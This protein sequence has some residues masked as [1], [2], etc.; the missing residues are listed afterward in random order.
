MIRNISESGGPVRTRTGNQTV[1]SGPVA[2]SQDAD[3]AR[4]IGTTAPAATDTATKTRFYTAPLTDLHMNEYT[5]ERHGD[6]WAL[7]RGRSRERHGCRL[8]NL[9][10]GDPVIYMTIAAAMN[11]AKAKANG[12]TTSPTTEMTG[13]C[14]G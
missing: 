11:F 3:S 7:Y 6:G 10:D 4:T 2:T 12:C 8:C 5:V 1:M 14:N 13:G 9:T